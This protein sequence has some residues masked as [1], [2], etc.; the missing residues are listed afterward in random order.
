MGMAEIRAVPFR[1]IDV[2]TEKEV[3]KEVPSCIKYTERILRRC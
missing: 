1:F 3:F 2:L